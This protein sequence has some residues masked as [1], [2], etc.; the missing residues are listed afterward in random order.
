V[1][2]D[3]IEVYR[4]A[5]GEWRWKRTDPQGRR[6]GAATEGYEHRADAIANLQRV[7]GPETRWTVNDGP[8]ES[9]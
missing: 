4:D 1:T 2:E 9:E 8:E 3:R 5:A 6:I 7:N